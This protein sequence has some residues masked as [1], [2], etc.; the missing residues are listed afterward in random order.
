MSRKKSRGSPALEKTCDPHWLLWYRL[1][2]QERWEESSRL[3]AI[4]RSLGGSLD[5]EPETGD[6]FFDREDWKA[7]YAEWQSGVRL[8]HTDAA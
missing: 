5:P 7:A 8:R 6:P 1:T 2:P 3:F 4:Y